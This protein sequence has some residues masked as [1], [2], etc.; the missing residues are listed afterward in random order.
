MN[1]LIYASE[2][3]VFSLHAGTVKLGAQAVIKG[4]A[5]TK[6]GTQI[7]LFTLQL[8]SNLPFFFLVLKREAHRTDATFF[9]RGQHSG[10]KYGL[11]EEN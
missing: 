4:S 8:V 9:C 10:V 11:L 2:A 7:P 6:N 3:P 1:L 5:V